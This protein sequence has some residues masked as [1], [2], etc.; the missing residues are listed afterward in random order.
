M[1][2][3]RSEMH[4]CRYLLARMGLM[5]RRKAAH[6]RQQMQDMRIRSRVWTREYGEDHPDVK[7]W[8]WPF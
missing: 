2:D 5:A 8:T 3:R 4:H 1:A 7:N 6:L